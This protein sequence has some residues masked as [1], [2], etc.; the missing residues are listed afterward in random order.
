MIADKGMRV[1]ANALNQFARLVCVSSL[2]VISMA[3]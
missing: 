3:R 1:K 2:V